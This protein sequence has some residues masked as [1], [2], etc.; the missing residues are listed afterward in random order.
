MSDDMV[1][2]SACGTPHGSI[3]DA[4]VCCEKDKPGVVGP[5]HDWAMGLHGPWKHCRR[6]GLIANRVVGG[7]AYKDGLKELGT[8]QPPCKGADE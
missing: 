3:E 8:V 5:K 6:C 2:C 1:R 4:T 7:W